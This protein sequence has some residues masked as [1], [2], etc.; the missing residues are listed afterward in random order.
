MTASW[1]LAVDTASPVVGAAL[2][3]PDGTSEHWSERVV[4]G[5]DRRLVPAVAGLLAQ[6]DA[7]G[8]VIARLGVVVG[9]GA[10]TGLRVGVATVLGVATARGVPVV[11]L[12]SLRVRAAAAPGHAQVL[13]LLDARKGRVYAGL[14]DT[15]GQ[16]PVA[17][18][19]ECD[20]PLAEVLP[21]APFVA[22]GEGALVHADAIAAAGGRVLAGPASTAATAAL[23]A[24]CAP[25]GDALD[26]GDVA[27]RYLRAPDAVPPGDLGRRIGD[28]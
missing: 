20:A 10:F 5:A 22:V 16:T 21:A 7:A 9:P 28:P 15:T 11:P 18:A 2:R 14:F 26:A 25:D 24:A 23:L 12:S 8:A 17:L 6:A 19:D 13:A 4:R 27:L 1:V 3:A